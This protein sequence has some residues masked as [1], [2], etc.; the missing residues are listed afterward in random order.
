MD[1]S[2]NLLMDTRIA[3]MEAAERV[4]DLRFALEEGEMTID[5]TSPVPLSEI[6]YSMEM[7]MLHWKAVKGLAK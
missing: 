1:A 7:L 5:R 6:E 4:A 2:Y 3:L